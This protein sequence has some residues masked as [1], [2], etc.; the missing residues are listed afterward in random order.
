MG[1]ESIAI[2]GIKLWERRK[3]AK[4]D[5][6]AFPWPSGCFCVVFEVPSGSAVISHLHACILGTVKAS[7]SPHRHLQLSFVTL[8]NSLLEWRWCMGPQEYIT[9]L[10]SGWPSLWKWFCSILI[11]RALR[12]WLLTWTEDNQKQDESQA[13]LHS[14]CIC[15][16]SIRSAGCSISFCFKAK[17]AQL[18]YCPEPMVMMNSGKNKSPWD[19]YLPK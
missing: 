4:K 16:L 19:R 18:T 12:N 14:F 15:H 1:K 3:D 11:K 7:G 6:E 17:G 5:L 13:L 9:L 8:L 2:R 10:V